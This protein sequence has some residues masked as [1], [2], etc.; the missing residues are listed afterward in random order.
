MLSIYTPEMLLTSMGQL[1]HLKWAYQCCLPS[2]V[3]IR[4]N[5]MR[6]ANYW[7]SHLAIPHAP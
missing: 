1:S 3:D 6:I 7:E 2:R 5:K 4:T